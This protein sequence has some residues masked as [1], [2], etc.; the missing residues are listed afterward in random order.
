MP[1]KNTKSP[2]D[3]YML[4][5]LQ[6]NK[7]QSKRAED[8]SDRAIQLFM[9]LFTA[10]FGVIIVI[11]GNVQDD[12][13]KYLFIGIA[14]L[15][16]SGFGVLTFAWLAT[17]NMFRQEFAMERFH[18]VQYFHDQDP[19]VFEKYG[20]NIYSLEPHRPFIFPE[21]SVDATSLAMSLSLFA[22]IVFSVLSVSISTYLILLAFSIPN[23]FV[24]LAV[25]ITI[26]VALLYV[27]RVS[28]KRV[29]HVRL[30]SQKILLEQKESIGK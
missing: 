26:L 13:Q 17:A 25:G 20:Q 2:L 3:D 29:K 6:S 12:F 30:A 14:L 23:L 18:L 7:A 8:R 11:N 27:W 16:M 4:E 19:K 28:Q 10:L 22:L 5:I 1:S 21:K 24:P 15:I 9:G